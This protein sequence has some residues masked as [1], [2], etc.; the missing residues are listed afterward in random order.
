MAPEPRPLNLQPKAATVLLRRFWSPFAWAAVGSLTINVVLF[1][2]MPYLLHRSE[3]LPAFEK[4]IPHLNVI[5]IKRPDL[6]VE[7]KAVRLPE[8]VKPKAAPPPPS[9]GGRTV[10]VDLK[11]AFEINPRLSGGPV[12]AAPPAVTV[13]ALDHSLT[14]SMVAAAELDHP[15][16]SVSRMPPVYPLGAKRRGIEGWVKVRFEVDTQGNVRDVKVIEARPPGV[17]DDSVIGCMRGWRFIPGTVGGTPVSA[18]AE[19]T[20]RFEL[21]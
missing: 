3:D 19:T 12:V 6:P 13:A 10:P 17:F 20:V 21:E 14:S 7:R 2:L 5:R 4:V 8:P 15:L 18:W 11:L 1:A 9:I 16:T